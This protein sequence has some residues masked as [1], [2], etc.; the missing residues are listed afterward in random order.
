[1]EFRKINIDRLKHAE[2]NP[3]KDLK[4]GDAEFEKIKNSIT[5]FGYCEPIIVN[6]DMTII[7]GHQRAKV[8]KELG[9][10]EI[11][12]VVI[13]IDKTKEKALNIALNKVTGEWDFESLAKLLDELKEEDYN[14][15]LTGFDFSEAEKLWDEYIS[16][17]KRD[18][19]KDDDFDIELPEEPVTKRGDIWL[20]GKHR[21]MCGDACSESDVAALMREDFADMVFTDPPWNVNY[22][23]TEHPSWKQRTI[24][25]DSMTTEEF[26]KFLDSAFKVMNKFSKPGCMTY[27]VMSAQ[28]WGNLMLSLK[29][30]GYHWSSTIIWNKDRLVLSRKDYHTKYEPIWYGWSDGSARLHPLTDRQQCDVWDIPRPSVSE[31]HPTTK[32]VELVVRAIK[33]SSNMKDIVLDLFGG[34]GTTLIAC[35]ET[36]RRCRMMELDEK[37]AD[38]IVKRYIDK[39]GSDADVFVLR[40]GEKIRYVDIK[41]EQVAV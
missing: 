4:P 31:L 2:Y 36:D 32:P 35:E 7:G 40:D 16:E 11:D 21:L 5:E 37:Y 8:L 10:T 33:N 13:N 3:R 12:C 26:K 18:Y 34:S 15:E 9:Y 1:L 14:I 22:G 6:S 39:V 29:E 24:L 20:L 25:N 28:E 30:N 23:A 27:V 17:N 19:Y 41:R 38:V